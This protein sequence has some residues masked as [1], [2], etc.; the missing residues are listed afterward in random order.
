MDD[1]P[2]ARGLGGPSGPSQCR[3][4]QAFTGI[5][6]RR[7]PVQEGPFGNLS[8]TG[9]QDRD[10]PGIDCQGRGPL[11][12]GATQAGSSL[13]GE[14]ICHPTLA[15]SKGLDRED[16]DSGHAASWRLPLGQGTT[17]TGTGEW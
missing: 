17:I 5:G 1:D 15:Q 12:E 14:V 7:E 16:G 4:V 11:G 6:Y 10:Q 3:A 2:L 9:D 8:I 13:V